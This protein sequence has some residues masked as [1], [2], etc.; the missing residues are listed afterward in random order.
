MK[1]PRLQLIERSTIAFEGLPLFLAFCLQET[2]AILEQ[3]HCPAAQARLFPELTDA[4]AEWKETWQAEV[5]PDL[6]AM[7]Q[8]AAEI[9]AQDLLRLKPD[10]QAPDTYRVAF[11]AA[12]LDA[13]MSAVNQARLTLAAL[14]QVSESDLKRLRQSPP[15]DSRDV[16]IIKI[17]ALGYLLELMVA[18]QQEA[19]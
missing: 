12:H 7:F 5:I 13:W 4:D 17:H 8:S 10:P 11:P 14:H 1:P 15:Q 9:F 18:F 19:T 3:R 16:A 6:E 2:P